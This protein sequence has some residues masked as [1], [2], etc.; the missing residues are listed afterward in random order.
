MDTDWNCNITAKN[1]RVDAKRAGEHGLKL[2]KKG[3]I[4]GLMH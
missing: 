3:K 1:K 4:K 2:Q